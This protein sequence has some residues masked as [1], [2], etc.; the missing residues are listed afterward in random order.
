VH[1]FDPSLDQATA[2]SWAHDAVLD[3]MIESEARRAHDM[4]MAGQ[5]ATGDDALKEFTDVVRQDISAGK[6]VQKTYS[7]DRVQLTLFLPKFSTQARRLVGVTLHGTTTLVTRDASGK[8]LSQQTL[9]YAKS[10]GLAGDTD[11]LVL[12]N[13]YTDLTLAEGVGETDEEVEQSRIVGSLG[14]LLV[15]PA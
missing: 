14:D 1:A 13:D 2:N 5:G 3:L 6:Y 7:F 10:W 8:V 9:S 12:V 11:H 4:T 15:G